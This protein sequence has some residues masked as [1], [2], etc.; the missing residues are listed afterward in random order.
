MADFLRIIIIDLFCGFYKIQ[1]NNHNVI[2]KQQLPKAHACSQCDYKAVDVGPRSPI[3]VLHEGFL[4][5]SVN[6]K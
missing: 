3:L 5:G 2:I 1:Y 6:C 4:G